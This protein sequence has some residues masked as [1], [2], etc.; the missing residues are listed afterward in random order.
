MT[1]EKLNLYAAVQSGLSNLWRAMAEDEFW[2]L[3]AEL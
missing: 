1:T 2:L 3:G